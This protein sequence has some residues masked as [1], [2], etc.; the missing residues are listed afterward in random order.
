MRDREQN[1]RHPA[2]RQQPSRALNRA[3]REVDP[4]EVRLGLVSHDSA[5]SVQQAQRAKECRNPARD[6][7]PQRGG[8]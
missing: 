6:S 2:E 1:Q 7:E 4:A 8:S 5:E 3:G